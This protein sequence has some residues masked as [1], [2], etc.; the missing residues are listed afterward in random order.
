MPRNVNTYCCSVV[1]RFKD[2]FA[3]MTKLYRRHRNCRTR[4]R[5]TIKLVGVNIN[6]WRRRRNKRPD[7]HSHHLQHDFMHRP[8]FVRPDHLY[9]TVRFHRQSHF[10]FIFFFHQTNYRYYNWPG[11][12]F[13]AKVGNSLISAKTDRS[14][15]YSNLVTHRVLNHETKSTYNSLSHRRW[16]YNQWQS[17]TRLKHYFLLFW[18]RKP[19]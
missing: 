15:M 2:H 4:S 14:G 19:K 8:S 9:T 6:T 18:Y 17:A 3:F 7:F 13:V 12:R 16:C 10:R 1:N 11:C 5:G